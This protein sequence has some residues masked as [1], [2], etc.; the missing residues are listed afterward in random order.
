ME[1]A[2]RSPE[3]SS[4]RRASIHGATSSSSERV[5][6]PLPL[7]LGSGGV[8]LTDFRVVSAVE[9]RAGLVPVSVF[10]TD[11]APRERRHGGFD[12]HAFPPHVIPDP[13][14]GARRR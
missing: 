9:A 1:F 2:T 5:A 8:G 11:G 10:K 14:H 6:A 4:P 7:A 12:S 13:H 3:V